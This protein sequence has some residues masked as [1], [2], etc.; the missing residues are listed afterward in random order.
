MTTYTPDLYDA[1]RAAQR[2]ADWNASVAARILTD[3]TGDANDSTRQIVTNAARDRAWMARAD[4]Y[5]AKSLRHE[6]RTAVAR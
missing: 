5:E 6:H 3:R 1:G 4:W 2:S